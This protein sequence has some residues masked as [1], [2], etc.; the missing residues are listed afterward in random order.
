MSRIF[1]APA[2]VKP[3]VLECDV[4]VGLTRRHLGAW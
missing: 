3:G 1:H 4:G 2:W